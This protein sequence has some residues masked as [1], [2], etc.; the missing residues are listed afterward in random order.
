VRNKAVF[1]SET[2]LDFNQ[3]T[4]L[5]PLLRFCRYSNFLIYLVWAIPNLEPIKTLLRLCAII[6]TAAYKDRVNNKITR[7]DA[8]LLQSVF[9]VVW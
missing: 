5:T 8:Y 9:V 3:S 7:D 6:K 2:R 4:D 1:V